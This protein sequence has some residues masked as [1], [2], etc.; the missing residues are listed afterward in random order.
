MRKGRKGLACFSFAAAAHE[1]DEGGVEGGEEAGADGD[2]VGGGRRCAMGIVWM[3]M[4]AR[5][6]AGLRLDFALDL[7]RVLAGRGRRRDFLGEATLDGSARW[8][9]MRGDGKRLEKGNASTG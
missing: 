5:V 7:V 1:C 9:E 8:R 3:G 6:S 4:G 2:V